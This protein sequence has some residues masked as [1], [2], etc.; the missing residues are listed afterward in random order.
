[1]VYDPMADIERQALLELEFNQSF[2]LHEQPV[3]DS[4]F[5]SA[6]TSCGCIHVGL[7]AAMPREWN[8]MAKISSQYYIDMRELLV[9]RPTLKGQGIG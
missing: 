8:N 1:M 9:S 5:T 7:L 3:G 6:L 2:D 4:F